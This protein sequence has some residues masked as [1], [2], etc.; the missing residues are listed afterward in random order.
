MGPSSIYLAVPTD[1]EPC[2]FWVDR[3]RP[4]AVKHGPAMTPLGDSPCL[5]SRR[6]L[7]RVRHEQALAEAAFPVFPD[8]PLGLGSEQEI[9]QRL[10]AGDIDTRRVLR[11]ELQY[12]VHV[13]EQRIT[14]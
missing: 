3:R 4:K 11:I 12:V 1:Q 8:Q 5:L 10:A 14:F 6:V 7:S 2:R 13:V 9:G